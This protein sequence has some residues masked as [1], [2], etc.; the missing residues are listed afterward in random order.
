MVRDIAWYGDSAV[1]PG[2]KLHDD[3]EGRPEQPKETFDW[4]PFNGVITREVAALCPAVMLR[5]LGVAVTAKSGVAV[6]E[7]LYAA[8]ATALFA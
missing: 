4:N 5:E 8:E 3:P 6:T 1:G 2:E 7:M